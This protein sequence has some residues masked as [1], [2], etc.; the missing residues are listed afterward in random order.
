MSFQS[1]NTNQ[2][3]HNAS[4]Y[5]LALLMGSWGIS[6]APV[7]NAVHT[8]GVSAYV[9]KCKVHSAT[10]IFHGLIAA[11][12]DVDVTLKVVRAVDGT[13]A[14]LGVS[15]FDENN[16]TAAGPKDGTFNVTEINPGD[17]VY[18]E[19]TSLTGSALPQVSLSVQ[20]RPV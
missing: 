13:V 11:S 20:L 8:L 2:V 7:A 3:I 14:T 16:V 19:V 12:E 4:G 1:I 15:V 17:V 9:N 5:Y 6:F 10:F 18:A